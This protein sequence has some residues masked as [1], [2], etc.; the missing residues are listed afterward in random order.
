MDGIAANGVATIVA[1][2]GL[3]LQAGGFKSC[4]V[5]Y[6]KYEAHGCMACDLDP[7]LLTH[8]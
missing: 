7:I 2:V 3:R 6:R 1:I 4:F 5:L 8:D